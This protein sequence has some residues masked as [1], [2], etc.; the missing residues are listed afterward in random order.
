MI[1]PFPNTINNNYL[2]AIIIFLIISF[3]GSLFSQ[4]SNLYFTKISQ[5]Q[6][7]P[8][9]D[10]N[11]IVQDSLGFIWVGA[12]SGL[13]KYDG[14]TFKSYKFSEQDTNSISNGEIWSLLV[15]S[16]HRLWVGT[17]IE[18]ISL[19][20]YE[21]DIFKRFIPEAG[22]M[23]KLGSGAVR[24][25][26]EDV[27]GNI[28][29]GTWGSGLYRLNE[30]KKTFTRYWNQ[31]KNSGTLS[32]NIVLSIASNKKGELWVGTYGGGLNKL[33][34]ESGVFT[35][36]RHH[37]KDNSS[38]S[39]DWINN[40]CFDSG[41]NL[42]IAT[43]DKGLNKFNPITKKFEAYMHN[44]S[45][46]NSISSDNTFKVIEDKYGYMWIVLLDGGINRFDPKTKK[47]TLHKNQLE[48]S[49]SIFNGRIKSIFQDNTGIIWLGNT[50]GE[51]NMHDPN[52]RHF[53]EISDHPNLTKI[54]GFKD[55]IYLLKADKKTIWIGTYTLGMI[56]FDLNTGRFTNFS[57]QQK[58]PYQL[59]TNTVP[60]IVMDKDSTIWASNFGGGLY[61]FNIK[62]KSSK[63]YTYKQKNSLNNNYTNPLAIDKKGNVWIGTSGGGLNKLDAETGKFKYFVH[64]PSNDKSI[65]S[66]YINYLFFDSNDYLWI[67]TNGRGLNRYE[68]EK[69]IFTRY[70]KDDS[71][72]LSGNK[73]LFFH[74]DYEGQLWIGTDG[75][76]SVWNKEED[77]FTSY[78][79]KDGLPDNSICCILEDN[80]KNLWISTK[81]GL[82][83]FSLVTKK[84]TNFDKDDGLQANEFTHPVGFKDKNGKMYFGGV[85]G[86]NIFYPD[87]III[88]NQIPK[89]IITEFSL[90]HMPVR[91]NKL[92]G[93]K[94][95]LDKNINLIKS[96]ELDHSNRVF[97]FEFTAINFRNPLRNQFAYM[98]EGF[99]EKWHFVDYASRNAT[100][101]N[102]PPGTYYFRV[103]ASN[104]RGI[105][106]ETGTSVKVII[107][108]P[109][110]K[111]W[112]AV[113]IWTILILGTI[114]TIYFV[115]VSQL[116][117]QKRVLE[118]EVRNRTVEIR[119]QKEEIESQAEELKA[120]NDKLVELDGFKQG[121]TGMIVHDLKNP[122]NVIINTPETQPQTGLTRVKNAGRQMLNMV[123]NI[124][125]VYKYEETAF[126][127]DK[128]D[129]SLNAII[130]S[131][132]QDV[133]FL[134][135]QKS[136]HIKNEINTNIGVKGDEAILQRVIVNLLTNAIKYSPQNQAITISVDEGEREEVIISVADNGSGI[137]DDKMDA[138]FDRFKQV[139]AKSS[140]GIRS[141]GLGL[142]FCKMAIEGHGG[143]IGVESKKDVGTTFWFTLTKT[144]LP[145]VELKHEKQDNIEIKQEIRLTESEKEFL[146][147][148][149]E[150]MKE[151]LV[152][153]TS[154]ITKILAEV[155][156]ESEA[157][158]LWKTE[159]EKC[160]YTM[161]AK[162]YKE[163][164]KL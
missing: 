25:I 82:S 52:T 23:D 129:C 79:V 71:T 48:N 147:T 55:F 130:Q 63:I 18:G 122:L 104:D 78:T 20:D 4:T 66:D 62:D 152:Y 43:K 163:L 125:D 44:S 8:R 135:E 86:I 16:K 127:V 111:T 26:Y 139:E 114:L 89:V 58:A 36:Y 50:Y 61:T 85:N 148:Y 70:Y 116:K 155:E 17:S 109:W 159:V 154:D 35:H 57:T 15:D 134:A 12:L 115:R 1:M 105:W 76:L 46:P 107:H 146:L 110:W 38:I 87:S 19:Y 123:L 54:L 27:E 141:T 11:S 112:W 22:K 10:I 39:S 93:N 60:G 161:N 103:K 56:K 2:K 94:I 65:S 118:N 158:Q 157:I 160:L 117:K 28:W 75:G 102:I 51:L 136:I 164:L 91:P 98:L 24:T 142:T 162:E 5:D 121:M 99:D 13:S 120:T 96:I 9:G 29:C 73:V 32:N 113:S 138:V 149:V 31:E 131:A 97:G 84:F 37:A 106:N 132:V 69:D 153:E 59:K 77:N 41:G 67:A 64:S 7:A 137:P 6:G 101:T 108:P 124:L 81:N 128:V 156:H 47:F 72:S 3:P 42:W 90:N 150:R 21:K 144:G 151:F 133:H 33:D 34:I 92:V 126:I 119:N 53:S 100:Y 30:D 74:E 80:H 83:K 140:G 95:I 143:E 14:Y 68:T 49:R 40:I 145:E 45:D 88:N